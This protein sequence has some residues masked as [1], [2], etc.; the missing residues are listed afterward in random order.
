M[1][2]AKDPKAIANRYFEEI[3]NQGNLGVADEIISPDFVMEIPGFREQ[4][5]PAFKQFVTDLRTSFPDLRFTLE[6]EIA[7]DGKVAVRWTQLGTHKGYL[8]DIPPTGKQVSD[9]GI[10]IFHVENGKITGTWLCEDTLGVMRQV[11]AVLPA[12]P[13]PP[14][15]AQSP[16]PPAVAP[17][18][19]ASAGTRTTPSEN[20]ALVHRYIDA[21]M[22]GHD[23][24]AAPQLMDQ[25]CASKLPTLSEP[26]R[27]PEG[28][29]RI[30]TILRNAMP[31][32]TSTIEDEVAAGDTVVVRWTSRGT[33]T[34][35][36]GPVPPTNK[37]VTIQGISWLRV[38]GG[39][40]VENLVNEDQLGLMRQ[41]GAVPQGRELSPDENKAMVHR[42]FDGIW[43]Q[44]NYDLIDQYIAENFVQHFPGAE[45]GREGFR[46]TVQQFH[47]AFGQMNLVI[48]D[49]IAAVDRVVHR[50][51]WN[52]THTGTFAG[53]PAT[54]RKVSF[55]GVTIVRTSGGM[56]A[57]HWASLDTLG[58]LQQL[59]TIPK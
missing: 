5:I 30:I 27:G 10:N 11:G 34:R 52:C 28:W 6:R 1:K 56:I 54:G 15:A 2:A 17:A 16:T 57:E 33:N 58:L 26:V 8:Y 50:W 36:F 24:A 18:A 32:L 22:S 48:E 19:P 46:R 37:K 44:S 43:N 59:G 55:P 3:M 39:K 35:N 29:V 4:G 25:N 20:I 45:S 40:L 13:A 14:P 21:V 53:I 7:D 42:F 31:D 23:L 38:A 51:T 49:E 9:Q 12:A 47:S 41:I